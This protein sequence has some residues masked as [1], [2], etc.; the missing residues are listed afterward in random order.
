MEYNH[1]KQSELSVNS[2][3]RNKSDKNLLS[4]LHNWKII[5]YFAP[6]FAI[7]GKTGGLLHCDNY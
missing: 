5:S 1:L 2:V 6:L 4:K 3:I 7:S